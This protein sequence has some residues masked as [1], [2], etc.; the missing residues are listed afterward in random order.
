[1]TNVFILTDGKSVTG[2]VTNEAADIVTIRNVEGVELKL[3]VEDI[4]EPA[5]Q[6][7]SVMPEGVAKDLTLDDFASL[8][9]YLES[10]ASRATK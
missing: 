6:A 4:E 2:F 3:K 9:A 7:I 8:I 5:K 10:L 1:M